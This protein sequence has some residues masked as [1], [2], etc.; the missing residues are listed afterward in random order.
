MT[1]DDRTNHGS[2]AA[3]QCQKFFQIRIRNSNRTP[4][5]VSSQCARLDQALNGPW[6][7]VEKLRNSIDRPELR[8]RTPP[9]G[10]GNRFDFFRR[11]D[12]YRTTVGAGRPPV[13]LIFCETGH[14]G[15][16]ELRRHD[17][18]SEHRRGGADRSGRCRNYPLNIN[19]T[20][21]AQTLD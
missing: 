14:G 8:D 10:S 18:S 9:S 13:F 4:D 21:G 1:I 7:Y 17:T 19:D 20:S 15:S 3:I 5:V 6:R 16:R 2:R 12:G 11:P